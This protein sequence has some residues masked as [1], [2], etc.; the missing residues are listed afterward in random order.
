[1]TQ[2]QNSKSLDGRDAVLDLYEES[3]DL[4]LN[5]LCAEIHA[6]NKRWWVDLDTGLPIERNVG[7]LLML[8]V[9]E[10]AEAMEGHRKNLNDDKLVNRPMLEVELADA[11]IRIFDLAGGMRLDLGG[12]LLEKL[13]YNVHRVDHSIEHRKSANGKKY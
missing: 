3:Y 12:A 7:E 1:M 4:H 9:S 11:M 10:I 5:H 2:D 8:I 6:L 13:T